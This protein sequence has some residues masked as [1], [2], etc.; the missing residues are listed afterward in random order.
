MVREKRLSFKSRVAVR[1]AS[2]RVLQK[3][4]KPRCGG[5]ELTCLAVQI[6]MKLQEHFDRL[7]DEQRKEKE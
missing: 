4:R 1:S 2:Y 3:I 5:G 7:W 6:I